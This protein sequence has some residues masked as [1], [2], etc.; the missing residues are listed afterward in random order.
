MQNQPTT[1]PGQSPG[2]VMFPVGIPGVEMKESP[3]KVGADEPPPLPINAK[4]SA[5]GKPTP[6]VD[7]R[8]KVTGSARYTADVKLP[9]MLYARM[10]TSTAPHAKIKTIDISAAERAPG[11]KAVHILDRDMSAAR[12]SDEAEQKY[13][14]IRYA[15]QPVGAVAAVTQAQ[16]DDAARLVKIEYEP[17]PFVV[18]IEKARQP[19]API[20]FAGKAEQA[21]TAGGG[22][23]ARNVEQKGNVRGPAR[24]NRGDVEQGFREAEVVVEAE[25]R[26]QVQTHSAL[27]THGVVADF[28]P[29]LLTVYAST[30]GTSSVRDEL[31][32]VFALKRSQVR[33][34]TE[35][36]GGGFGAKFGAGNYGVLA[37]HLSR[38][39]GVPVRLMLDRRE[40]HL[41][42]G[43]RPSS[44]QKIRIGARKDGS[45]TAIELKS[46]GTAGV[47]TGAGA[48]G[49]TQNMYPC[50]NL[51][52]EDSDVFTNAGPAAAFRAPGHP[53]GAFSLE[54][55][56]D[57]LAEKLRTDPLELREKIDPLES[58]RVQRKIG[59]DRINW[60]ARHAPGADAGP[61]KRGIGVAQAI[62]Y[63]FAN[64]DSAC[65]VRISRD[66]SV[67]LMSAVQDI[68]GGI[69]TALAQCAA[70]ELGLRPEQIAVKIGDTAFPP[71]PGSGGS[72]TTNSITPPARNAAF[73]VSRDLLRQVAP[74][75]G[76]ESADD[77][78]LA[79]GKVS[80]RS[81]PGKSMSFAAACAK[82][83][84]DQIT[85]TAKRSA[86]FP[87]PDAGGGRAQGRRSPAGQLGGVQFAEVSVD[88]E[89]GVIKVLRVVAVH[90]CGRPINP[91]ALESQINGGIIQGISYALH[92]NRLLDRNTGIMVNPNLEQYKIAGSKDTPVIEPILIEQYWGRSSTDAAGIGEPATVPT[93]AAVANAVY[94]AI[95]VRIRELPMTPA[96][97]LRALHAARSGNGRSVMR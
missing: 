3:R 21:G 97:V 50:A 83:S 76:V 29:D 80:V 71:G 28:K 81:D 89:T 56:V 64:A 70:E 34:I 25:F 32:S 43:N 68:G 93:A 60:I 18:D 53:Q 5:I 94:N 47:G 16:A 24:Q 20:I 12:S 41:S 74:A 36:M 33:V 86:D 54:Q 19:D 39:S 37:T 87:L 75:L 8:A 27:E 49:P 15:G 84:T 95:G 10:I 30:Q 45:L 22:G 51:L 48:T 6:R 77:L 9:G 62:W 73:S 1:R 17:L 78:V 82:L 7:G 63:R 44:V 65:E 52:T 55:A 13:P 42:V 91:L 4:L 92:E 69:K 58:R 61:V 79:D 23:G 11:V 66:G 31:S 72:V 2:E 67:E 88:V 96:V 35:F 57:E 38:K 40:E 46:Y 85:A 26:T 59:A 14:T 90:D